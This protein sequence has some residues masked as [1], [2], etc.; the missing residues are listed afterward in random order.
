MEVSFSW[1]GRE[2]FVVVEPTKRC[3]VHIRKGK[4]LFDG[5][6][7]HLAG[8]FILIVRVFWWPFASLAG[9]PIDKLQLGI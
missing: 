2:G 8:I 1:G 3:D 7:L 5:K 4:V 9:V 6:L